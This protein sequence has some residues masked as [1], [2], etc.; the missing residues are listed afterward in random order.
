MTKGHITLIVTGAISVFALFF[1]GTIRSLIF[2]IGITGVVGCAT[3]AIAIKMLFDRMYILPKQ[4]KWP[5]PYSGILELQRE[6]IAQA[7]GWVVAK[8]LVC[9]EAVL[10]MIT[11]PDFRDSAQKILQSKLH[12][13]ANNAE[14]LKILVQDIKTACM[15]FVESDIFR[16]NLQERLYQH[17]GKLGSVCMYFS[18]FRN[19]ET[20]TPYLQNEMKMVVQYICDDAVFHAKLREALED[21][22]SRLNMAHSSI[23]ENLQQHGRKILEELIHQIDLQKLV[24]N[25]IANFA[26][27]EL[28]QIV[29]K[30]TA[31]NLDWLEVWGGALGAAGGVLFWIIER[32]L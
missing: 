30:I 14:I 13:V 8:R 29:L 27:G 21:L 15:A 11:A 31:E 19:Y 24:A 22:L 28:S 10:R 3:N 7:I 18:I 9:P 16:N 5:L 17:F 20:A 6:K 12:S 25:E 1:E 23:K 32:C 4:E 2:T 26:P